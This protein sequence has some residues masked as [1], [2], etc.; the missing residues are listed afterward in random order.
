MIGR[1][2]LAHSSAGIVV[3]RMVCLVECSLDVLGMAHCLALLFQLF[4]LSC[5][6]VGIG[7]FFVLVLQEVLVLPVA[8]DVVLQLL[9]LALQL[10]IGVI[11]LMICCQFLAVL[12]HDVHHAQLEVLLV[13]QQVLVL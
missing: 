6:E 9:Q 10:L 13:Q 8:L 3:Q 2:H 7:Q 5:T 11:C 4:L 1:A 12:R